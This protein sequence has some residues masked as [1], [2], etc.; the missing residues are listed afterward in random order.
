MRIEKGFSH[1]N[2]Q[3]MR[4][5]YFLYIPEREKLIREVEKLLYE[6]DEE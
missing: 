6:S 4:T 1:Y 3:N 5:L 2:L